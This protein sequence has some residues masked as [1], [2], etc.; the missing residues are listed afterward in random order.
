MSYYLKISLLHR[1]L[2]KWNPSHTK[3]DFKHQWKYL[4]SVLCSISTKW[5]QTLFSDTLALKINV[6]VFFLEYGDGLL[7][8]VREIIN[9]N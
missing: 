7:F 6:L 5:K 4:V 1:S 2:K 3:L 9:E 8:V